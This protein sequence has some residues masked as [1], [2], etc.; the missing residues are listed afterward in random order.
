MTPHLP[1]ECFF[2]LPARR[3]CSQPGRLLLQACSMWP[4]LLDLLTARVAAYQLACLV[5]HHPICVSVQPSPRNFEHPAFFASS[6]VVPAHMLVL[7]CR[8]APAAEKLRVCHCRATLHGTDFFQQGLAEGLR[9]LPSALR[10]YA[11]SL[12]CASCQILCCRELTL[13]GPGSTSASQQT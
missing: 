13:D 6:L 12:A 11:Q 9:L 10:G 2:S 1:M 4:G 5:L 3:E 8:L 7:H